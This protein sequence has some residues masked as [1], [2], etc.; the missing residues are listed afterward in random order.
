MSLATAERAAISAT[1]LAVGPDRPTL[2]AGWTT[3]DLLAHLLVRE[4]RPWGMVGHVIPALAGVTQQ[5]MRSFS[6]IP[7]AERV[8]L[9]RS[10]PPTWSPF[11][12]PGID[13]LANGVEL[14]IH[15]E[16]VR[17]GEP[18]WEPRPRDPGRDAQLW[19]M[20]K[21]A[22]RVWY[23]RSPVGVILR[24]PDGD[25]LV[26]QTGQGVVTVVGE[27]SELMLHAFGR[28]AARVTVEG[29]PADVAAF[30]KVSR[31]V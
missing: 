6:D 14:F 7:W 16:D 26:V 23:R 15:H 1:L 12:I 8:E 10:G 28:D 27:P 31:R 22:G 30:A 11:R 20:L 18:G 21:R 9:L 13:E 24:R 17:R 29:A 19:A 2:C 3:A 4:R 25:S 5:A